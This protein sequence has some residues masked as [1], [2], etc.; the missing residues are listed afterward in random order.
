M[1]S[2]VYQ[3]ALS[4]LRQGRT[5]DAMGLLR[6][7]VE[8][9]DGDC[10]ALLGSLYLGG[11]AALPRNPDEGRELL[12]RAVAQCNRHGTYMYGKALYLGKGLPKDAK[13]GLRLIK[14]AALMGVADAQMDLAEHYAGSFFRRRNAGAWLLI[15]AENGHPVAQERVE[16]RGSAPPDVQQLAA[17]IAGTIEILGALFITL[18]ASE[19]ARRLEDMA[20][21]V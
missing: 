16:A 17:E 8:A 20:G 5:D 1:S 18:D 7:G 12:E 15:A 13:K 14:R 11:H 3:H 9:G 6:R 4:A 21:Q 2:D 19:A 10:Q